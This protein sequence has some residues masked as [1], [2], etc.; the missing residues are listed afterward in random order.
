[1][2]ALPGSEAL[3]AERAL[4]VVVVNA[5]CSLRRLRRL[6][7]GRARRGARVTS[8]P[9]ETQCRI[10]PMSHD[11][12]LPPA[13][14]PLRSVL[15]QA[16][17]RQRGRTFAER[18]LLG[19]HPR[20]KHDCTT[21]GLHD[22]RQDSERTTSE[23]KGRAVCVR[24]LRRRQTRA[25]HDA[26]RPRAGGRARTGSGPA[27]SALRS[28]LPHASGTPGRRPKLRAAA[29]TARACAGQRQ[30]A[31]DARPPATRAVAPLLHGHGR[32]RAARRA[33]TQRARAARAT[34][35]SNRA[36]AVGRGAGDRRRPRARPRAPSAG[37]ARRRVATSDQRRAAGRRRAPRCYARSARAGPRATDGAA[38][39][40]RSRARAS[41]LAARGAHAPEWHV[42]PRCVSAA[43]WRGEAGT[44]AGPRRVAAR[45]ARPPVQRTVLAKQSMN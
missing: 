9:A 38:R 7:R 45:G 29:W 27:Q 12:S 44:G 20:R 42:G 39:T 19:H 37:A 15:S 3:L 1:M 35:P 5:W 28:P 18:K 24:Q 17:L 2:A 25:T 43:R 6:R 23:A 33:G 13:R 8:Q 32:A 10:V 14:L 21:A 16:A 36:P 31:R 26:I 4:T 41:R 40:E 30:S 22:T 34:G 11:R